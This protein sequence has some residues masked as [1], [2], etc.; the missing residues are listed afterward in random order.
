MLLIGARKMDHDL[1]GL[2]ESLNDAPSVREQYVR[3]PIGYPGSKD[4]SLDYLLPHLPYSNGFCEVFGGTGAAMLA[5]KPSNLEVYNDRYGGIT[6]FYRVLRDAKKKD[7]LCELIEMSVHSR[8]EF[9]WCKQSW[10]TEDVTDDVD[11]AFRW[12]YMHQHSF[13]KKE[14]AFGRAT[15]GKAQQGK[16]FRNLPK[17]FYA[18]HERLRNVQIENL[19]WRVCLRDYDRHD[20]V[21][22]LDPTYLGVTRGIYKYEMSVQDHI[23]MCERI[24]ALEGFVALSGYDNPET[25]T[26][27]DRYEWDDVKSWEVAQSMQGLAFT[28]TNNLGGKE[29]TIERGRVREMLWIKEFK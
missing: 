12:L 1:L 27:Y 10:D 6:C 17:A 16:A 26:I 11:R 15:S 13:A 3:V 22:Y 8:E 29:N 9:V 25:H 18:V 23:E 28:D 20:M 4:R 7:R 5:R 21:F 24:M 19:D 14:N 2:F